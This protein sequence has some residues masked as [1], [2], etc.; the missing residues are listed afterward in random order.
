M[1]TARRRRA[2]SFIRQ[3][4]QESVD[5]AFAPSWIESLNEDLAEH[6]ETDEQVARWE[7]AKKKER[8]LWLTGK[9]WNDS[10]IMPGSVCA[11]L[12]LP[13]GSTYARA[14]RKLRSDYRRALHD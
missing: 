11:E 12:D 8:A 4:F 9:L 13:L 10:N 6:F 2:P 7:A 14:A 5:N 1:A 3:I